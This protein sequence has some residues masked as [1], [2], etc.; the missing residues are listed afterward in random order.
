LYYAS[1]VPAAL[2]SDDDERRPPCLSRTQ[3]SVVNRSMI[4]TIIWQNII[5]YTFYRRNIVCRYDSYEARR[6]V[7]HKIYR[8]YNDITRYDEYFT[9]IVCVRTLSQ[10][11][12]WCT[13]YDD[14]NNNNMYIAMIYGRYVAAAAVR[15]T[16]N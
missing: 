8:P 2:D 16:G 13:R 15:V 5:Q 12:V 6:R 3:N 7:R 1:R 10:Y 4:I 9:M 11:V 14:N